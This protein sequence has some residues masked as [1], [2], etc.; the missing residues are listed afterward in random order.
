MRLATLRLDGRTAAVRVELDHVVELP[1]ADVGALLRSGDDWFA[2]AAADGPAH[3]LDETRFA[4]VVPAPSKIFCVGINYLAH[5][6]EMKREV[7]THPT[8]FAKFAEALTGPRDDIDLPPESTRV[9]WE[10]EL[11]LVIGRRVRRADDAAAAAAIAG[12][13]VCNDLSMRDW[14]QRT[15]QWLQGK[16]WERGTPLGP[17]LVTADE[18][19]GPEP[20]LEVRAFVDGV[21]MQHGR[22]GDLRFKPIE[23]VRY[24]ST[25]ITLNPGDIISTGTPGG[26]GDARDPQIYLRPGNVLRTEVSGIGA[27]LNRMVNP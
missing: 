18:L 8:V 19:G 3:V 15:L 14:Q 20:D 4:A 1:A 10:A 2:S 24:V 22:T 5:I 23:L 25:F 26:V 16:T 21:Q 7:P 6:H 27:C 12:F 13:T 17:V 11:A 9:D